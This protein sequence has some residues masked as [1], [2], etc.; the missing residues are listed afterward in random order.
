MVSIRK[1]QIIVLVSNRIEYWSNY[2]IRFEISIIRTA[3]QQMSIWT[4]TTPQGQHAIYQRSITSNL[5]TEYQHCGDLSHSAARPVYSA[6]TSVHSHTVSVNSGT[7]SMCRDHLSTSDLPPQPQFEN[8][9][10][11]N[12]KKFAANLLRI[13][14]DG[15]IFFS[16]HYCTFTV[17][18]FFTRCKLKLQ[19][20]PLSWTNFCRLSAVKVGLLSQVHLLLH[21]N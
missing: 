16:L 10:F 8:S 14:K 20:S 13:L 2:S 9:H 1:F 3:L 17:L 6:F 21:V 5:T 18:H 12:F 11:T 4:T 19:R 15:T 7:L